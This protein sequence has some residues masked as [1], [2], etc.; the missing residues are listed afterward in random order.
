MQDRALSLPLPLV[1]R[2][3]ELATLRR[4]LSES[5]SGTCASVVVAGSYGLGKTRLLR[6]VEAQSAALGFLPAAGTAFR[7]EADVPYAV[8]VD[9]LTPAIRA[10]DPA[11]LSVLARGSEGE[12]SHVIPAIATG[13]AARRLTF[14][15]AGDP[16]TRVRWHFAQFLTR[17]SERQPL[18][19]S[20]D[21][22]QWAD[23]SSVALVHF[24]V[25]HAR[26]ARL[27]VVMAYNQ[28]EADAHAPFRTLART[29]ATSG[30][31]KQL[32]LAPLTRDDVRDLLAQA[33]ERDPDTVRE[34]ADR[35]FER[36]VGNPF[37][38]EETL[39]A[40]VER[41]KLRFLD[42]QWTGW[43][44]EDF[45]L[46]TSVREV[47]LER[48]GQLSSQGRIAADVASVIGARISHDLLDSACGLAPADYIAAVEEL[49][50]RRLLAERVEG[51][52]IVYDFAHPMVQSTIYEELAAVRRRDLHARIAELMERAFGE[53][54]DRHA[55]ELAHHFSR[56]GSAALAPRSYHY[57]EIAG[58]DALAR[59]ADREAAR[60]LQQALD[61]ADRSL[62]DWPE[63]EGAMDVVE[64]LARA[65]QRLGEYEAARALWLRAREARVR[66]ADEE[67]LAR[68]ER[69]L[70]LLMY[71]SGQVDQ[72]LAHFDAAL[73][74]ARR[75]GRW[76]VEVRTL[77][78]KGAALQ[79]LGSREEAR[80]VVHAALA[81]AEEKGDVGMMARVE[82]TLQLLYTFSGRADLASKYGSRALEHAAASGDLVVACSAHWTSA[83]LAG[84]TADGEGVLQHAREADRLARQLNSP[85]L[86]AQIAE[87]TIEYASANGD[88]AEAL[89]I[90]DRIIPVARA[91]APRTL[92]PRILVWIGMVR[93]YRD[94][95]EQAKALFDEAWELSRAS[96]SDV[97]VGDVHAVIVAYLGQAIYCLTTRDYV[98]SIEYARRGVEIADRHGYIV[99]CV[100]RLLPTLAEA[101][102]W[103]GDF[104]LVSR[105][106]ARLAE[107]AP[108]LEHSLAQAYVV[109]IS[110]V[111]RG[112]EHPSEG[113]PILLKAADDFAAVP[114]I[115]HSS[116]LRR[117]I[118][119]LMERSGDRE[120]AAAQ[121]RRAHDVF[122]RL[123][124]ALELRLT[125]D[126]MRRL[127][128]RPP[129][130]SVSSGSLL[131]GREREIAD[132]LAQH[133]SNK[134]I[135][136]ALGISA[137]TVSTHL[138]NMF[139][140]LGVHS[141]GEL[142]DAVRE[143]AA[144]LTAH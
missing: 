95:L 85:V 44:L 137:R 46:P 132:L 92:L 104:P 15:D 143:E 140:K 111:L 21:N 100:H 70:G 75:V 14:D 25:R 108:R 96:A 110:G 49:R 19:L 106:A 59:R 43:D 26:E 98:R 127:G 65:R 121:L 83:V 41:G 102:L 38:V 67:G 134:E 94:E 120:G 117:T 17:L 74:L 40:L 114:F 4:A 13:T 78:A 79:T 87:V 130:R 71:W 93:L 97:V 2:E 63:G 66:T 119:Q 138:S 141:R 29:L 61:L 37:F 131:S 109:A 68:I 52:A 36:T 6:A 62:P 113:I 72:S 55:T 82:R 103:L 86:V 142:V 9:A 84:L 24:I 10:L 51:D 48:V 35:L 122:L 33:F 116:R 39:K 11:T 32:S 115:F 28:T 81:I 80:D 129:Q 125:R 77:V 12:L 91:V 69:H 133:R 54:S 50:G 5:C 3:A 1:G 112:L 105:V 88:W 64:G 7:H 42:S 76:D 60:C 57:L 144:P 31:T 135:A 139:E 128:V 56:A 107:E 53:Q 16:T 58:Q 101:A 126:Q 22:A 23:P 27:T 118:A 89:A 45:D 34:F 47:I 99:W 73:A 8:M 124:A 136:R 90:A 18:L 123:G 20:I 30:T